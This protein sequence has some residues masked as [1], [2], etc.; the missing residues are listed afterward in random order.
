MSETTFPLR[1]GDPHVELVKLLK[2]T[3]LAQSGGHAKA[4]VAAGEV[5]VNGEPEDRKRRKLVP[6]D[7]VT[8]GGVTV[9]V[10]AP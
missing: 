1:P 3:D 6:G 9:E 4:L 7:R 5:R 10:V 2:A 8:L